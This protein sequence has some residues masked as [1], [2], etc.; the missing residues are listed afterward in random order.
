M[1]ATAV[2]GLLVG[3]VALTTAELLAGQSIGK[4][5]S[6]T[7]LVGGKARHKRSS[8]NEHD[9]TGDR[10]GDDY[11]P[12]HPHDTRGAADG[13][14]DGAGRDDSA[15]DHHAAR[16][17]DAALGGT[18]SKP[19]GCLRPSERMGGHHLHAHGPH[20]V[21]PRTPTKVA[22]ASPWR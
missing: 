13:H 6:A 14:R 2:I 11:R 12:D 15:D 21:R 19:P 4:G 8:G 3:A 7:S 16:D 10:G 17:A 5:D 1:I 20:T 18:R 22:C 9:H